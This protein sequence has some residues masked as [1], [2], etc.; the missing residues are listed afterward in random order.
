MS[1][2]A[3]KRLA[4]ARTSLRRACFSTT[5]NKRIL[6]TTKRSTKTLS[7]TNAFA[8]N[9]SAGIRSTH[10]LT[11]NHQRK[12]TNTHTTILFLFIFIDPFNV[13]G[14]FATDARVIDNK[15]NVLADQFQEARE[16]CSQLCCFRKFNVSVFIVW[17]RLL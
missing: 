11:I 8:L 2:A 3:A 10:S 4:L 1:V 9:H 17:L 16:V 13:V 6:Q 15:I 5:T 12:I 7:T 14:F